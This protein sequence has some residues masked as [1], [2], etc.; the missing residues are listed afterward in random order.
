MSQIIDCIV[1]PHNNV[2]SN[3]VFRPPHSVLSNLRR[4]EKLVREDGQFAK[5]VKCLQS[6]GLAPINEETRQILQDKHPSP[7]LLST[8]TNPL[9]D[10]IP[11]DRLGFTVIPL[12]VE[13]LVGG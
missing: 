2:E 6:K 13:S 11:A 7:S 9:G 4:A 8:L 1:L 12:P 5:A 3:P 10:E